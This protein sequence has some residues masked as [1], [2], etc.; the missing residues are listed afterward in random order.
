[1]DDGAFGEVYS[2]KLKGVTPVAVRHV[3][4]ASAT[5]SDRADEN[6]HV[7]FLKEVCLSMKMQGPGA[8]QY[9][10]IFWYEGE[11]RHSMV[12]HLHHL[13]TCVGPVDA[14][15]TPSLLWSSQEMEWHAPLF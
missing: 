14:D 5:D 6:K 2:A 15:P 7:D 8:L 13:L 1:L 9:Y 3:S 11:S 10:G 12:C 4:I